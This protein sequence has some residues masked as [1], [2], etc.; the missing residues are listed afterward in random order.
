MTLEVERIGLDEL[1]AAWEGP[2]PKKLV[3]CP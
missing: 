3:V 1:P 2:H